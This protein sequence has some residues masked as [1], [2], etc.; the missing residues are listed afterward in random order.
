MLKWKGGREGYN[1]H[2]RD[3]KRS[4]RQQVLDHYGN[5]CACCG[6]SRFEFLSMDHISGG[7]TADRRKSG[8]RGNA[9]IGWIIR[10]NYP[11]TFRILCHNCN[12]AIGF[13]GICPHETEK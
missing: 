13:Y 12:Q 1:D 8:L 11:D 10:N 6:E 7:G 5:K 3:Y 9:I 4:R 2:Q